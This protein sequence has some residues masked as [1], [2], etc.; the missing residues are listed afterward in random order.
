MHSDQERSLS[1]ALLIR[2][3]CQILIQMTEDE[4]KLQGG[5][6]GHDDTVGQ[7]N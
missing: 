2:M 5:T 7:G 1:A 6:I 3:L 4:R